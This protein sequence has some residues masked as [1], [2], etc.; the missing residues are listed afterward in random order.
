MDDAPIAP[1]LV[2]AGPTAVGKSE[3]ALA[4]AERLDGE[5]VVAD[6]RQVYRR[7]DVATAKPTPA[8]R[9]RVPHHLLDLV[10]P[11]VP[12]SAGDYAR[13]AR[14]AIAAIQARG[15][16]AIVCGGTGFYLAALAGG[17]DEIATGA[18]RAERAAA[19]ARVAA[20]PPAARHA[21]LAEVD[22][23][24]AARLHPRDLQRIDRALE[25]WHLTGEPASALR[26]GGERRLP[27]LAVRLVRPR[28]ELH[29]R[30]ERR[31][32]AML[33]AG[34]E[35]EARALW[36]E[37]RS[38]DEPGLDTIGVQEWWP[39]F[40]GERSLVETRRRI[41]VATRRYAKR[42]E[43]WFRHQGSYRPLPADRGPDPVAGWWRQRVAAVGR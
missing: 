41:L 13:D 25:V 10:D 5:I 11:G 21:A 43:T 33:D 3:I 16:T 34:L 30:I 12:F 39:R 17:L 27:H 42:Q 24:S 35:D 40:E 7:I 26:T 6:S 28:A 29:R 22:P 14:E 20:I 18:D 8:E 19:R 4:L 1:Y 9:A 37:G 36:E 23:S 31:L 38:P 32:D 2:V 15:R